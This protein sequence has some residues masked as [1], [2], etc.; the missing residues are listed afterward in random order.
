MEMVLSRGGD[1]TRVSGLLVL[2]ALA[3]LGYWAQYQW[4]S[5]PQW[6]VTLAI[7]GAIFILQ[8]I[9]MPPGYRPFQC[10]GDD[11]DE[12]VQE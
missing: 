5:D 4:L 8:W 6:R 2:L 9:I 1:P 11:D 10:K 3:V 7:G 12:P